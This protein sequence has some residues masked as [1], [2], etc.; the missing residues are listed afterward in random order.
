MQL[1]SK[2]IDTYLKGCKNIFLAN[3][4]KRKSALTYLKDTNIKLQFQVDRWGWTPDSGLG[5]VIRLYD[6]GKADSYGNV[7][8]EDMYDLTL[9]AM[10]ENHILDK[11]W[12]DSYKKLLPPGTSLAFENEYWLVVYTVGDIQ[13][14][15]DNILIKTLQFSSEWR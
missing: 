10:L 5:F 9:Y 6:V 11:E 13:T 4:F 3:G 1:N 12:L 8:P 14:L 15:I 2:D 7:R